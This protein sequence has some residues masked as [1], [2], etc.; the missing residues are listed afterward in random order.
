MDRFGEKIECN[1]LN[2]FSKENQ[3]SIYFEELNEKA[4]IKT[5][6]TRWK[7]NQ[8]KVTNL[9]KFIEKLD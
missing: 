3:F 4:F 5:K 2:F 1:K 8:L 9:F 6:C 7:K